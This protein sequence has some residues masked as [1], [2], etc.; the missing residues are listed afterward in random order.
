M[1]GK[2]TAE[3]LAELG[4]VVGETLGWSADQITAEVARVA[5]ILRSRHGVDLGAV[6]T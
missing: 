3:S 2:V 1:L 5:E 6:P 4:A